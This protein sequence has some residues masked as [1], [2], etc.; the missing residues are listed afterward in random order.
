MEVGKEGGEQRAKWFAMEAEFAKTEL[1]L[2]EME[3]ELT[4]MEPGNA[5]GMGVGGGRRSGGRAKTK[6]GRRQTPDGRESLAWIR[7][8]D[9]LALASMRGWRNTVGNLIELRWLE[10]PIAG[11]KLL[12]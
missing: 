8:F 11:R 2:T 10:K 7:S 1:D 12:V 9:E 6:A 4:E 5:G 3:P